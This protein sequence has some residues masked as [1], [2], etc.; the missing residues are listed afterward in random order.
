MTLDYAAVRDHP[1]PSGPTI[2]ELADYLVLRHHSADL[3]PTM[4]A[5]W[6]QLEE[7]VAGNTPHP[8]AREP[9]RSL[10]GHRH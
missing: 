7:A 6:R 3:A 2:G 8:A 10:N 5:P 4:R 9:V 1:G